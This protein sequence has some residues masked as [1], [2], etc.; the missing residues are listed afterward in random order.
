MRLFKK[1][2][3]RFWHRYRALLEYYGVCSTEDKFPT[4][5]EIIVISNLNK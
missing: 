5:E 3:C 4:I 2:L 1:P